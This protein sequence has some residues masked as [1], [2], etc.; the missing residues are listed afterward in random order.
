MGSQFL[1]EIRMFA[2]DF[3]PV[4]WA[5]CNGQLLPIAPNEALFQLIGTT[6]GGDGETT[7][8]LPD[9][10]GRLPV[11]QGQG[12]GLSNYTLAE[13]GGTETV[14]LT[15]AQMPAHSHLPRARAGAGTSDVPATRVWAAPSEPSAKIYTGGAPDAGMNPAVIKSSGGGLPHDNMPPFLAIHFI[16]ALEGIF[17]PQ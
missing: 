14:T 5:L 17:P 4:G 6:Y 3:A 16:I 8:A 13:L 9:L 7:F 15:P 12:P 11:S 10:R 2:G 1:G